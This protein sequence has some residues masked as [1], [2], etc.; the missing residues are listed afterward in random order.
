MKKAA[1]YIETRTMN[2]IISAILT[3]LALIFGVFLPREE[4]V[5]QTAKDL[6]GT[7]T[8][9]SVTLEQDSKKIDMYGAN[10]QGQLIF[11][12]IGRFSIVETRSDVPKFASNNREAGTSEENK[13]AVQGSIALFGTYSVSETD[14]VVTYHIEGCTFPNWRG[15]DQK[16]LFKLS[17]DEL[18]L[19]NPTPSTGSGN[20]L[21]VWRRVK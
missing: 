1:K 12:P 9:V 6:V 16:R 7:W 17:G 21:V 14:K 10:P 15:A 8:L 20:A 11:A 4:A 3:A 13:A 18:T 2:R 19:S 5:A